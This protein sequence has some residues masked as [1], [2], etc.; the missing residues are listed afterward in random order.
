MTS[1]RHLAVIR[2]LLALYQKYDEREISDAI[3]TIRRGEALKDLVTLA[4]MTG[5]FASKIPGTKRRPARSSA[6]SRNSKDRFNALVKTLEG[7]SGEH[8]DQIIVLIKAIASRQ[9]LQSAGSLREFSKLLH[10]GV[11]NT[12][13][14]RFTVAKKIGEALLDR[15]PLE[16]DEFFKIAMQLG[17]GRSSLHEWSDIIVKK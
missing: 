11:S 17:G 12:R 2:D 10:V 16:C 6:R 5:E 14:D 7:R 13:V 4:T 8:N 15:S 1:K 9:V 3:E